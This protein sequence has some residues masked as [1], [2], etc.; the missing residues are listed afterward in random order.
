MK[1]YI[2]ALFLLTTVHYQL[3]AQD[4]PSEIQ[5][6]N[7]NRLISGAGEVTGLYDPTVVNK[8]ELILEESN[9]FTLL[10]GSGG[11]G[12]GGGGPNSNPG[13]ELMGTLIFNDTVVLDSV[14]I[15]IKGET[16]DFANNS[17]KKSFSVSI[18]SIVNQDLLGYDN[19]NLNCGFQDPSGM[20]EVLYCNAT[21]SFAP[22]LK[23][24]IVDLYINGES[25]GP[26]ANVQQIEGTYIKEWFGSNDGT[27]W[28]CVSPEGVG[29]PGG[30]GG[31]GGPGGGG[32][33]FGLGSSTL[34]WLGTESAEY[35]E[36][37][38]LKNTNKDDPWQDLIDACDE[39][40]NT[41]SI[42]LYNLAKKVDIDRAL[43]FLAQ[44]I[45]FADDDS[46][47]NKG[48][49]DYYAYFDTDTDR[50]IPLEVDGNSVMYTENVNWSIYYNENDS[51]YVLQNRL[52]QNQELKQRYLSHVRVILE[53]NFNSEILEPA[54]DNYAALL[55]ARVQADPKAIYSYNEYLN[56]LDEL[57]EFVENR[58]ALFMNN[59]DV[60]QTELVINEPTLSSGNGIE[61][62]PAGGEE[63]EI[64]VTINDTESQ[65][66]NRVVL[67]YGQ[68]IQGAFERVTMA[69]QGN[70][71]YTASIASYP[72]GAYVRYY[73]EAVADNSQQTSSYLP[74]GAEHD[75]YIYQV[76]Q[77]SV[78]GGQVVINEL[79]AVND[80]VN[81]DEE[82][83]FDDWIE[84]YNVGDEAVNLSGYY[85]TDSENDLLKY[86]FPENTILEGDDYLLVWAD[87]NTEQ[88][89][90]HA[91]FKLS[92]GG[93][94]VILSN[95][96]GGQVDRVDFD[97]QT[98]DQSYSRIPNGT[99]DFVIKNATPGFNNEETVSG[100]DDLN[101]AEY[102][103]TPN[104]ATDAITLKVNQKG[105]YRV[106]I[107]TLLGQ[108]VLKQDCQ[109]SEVI[110]ISQLT[111]GSYLLSVNQSSQM[112]IIQ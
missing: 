6:I 2:V 85:L 11:G 55:D 48:G 106:S 90:Y 78:A 73:I 100:L 31:P 20:R 59:N 82:G 26:Y 12:P 75:I 72:A 57:K 47:V 92:S 98:I 43:W 104:P 27:R 94:S 56:D 15:G 74:K 69:D 62:A 32:T 24:N 89:A 80:A 110:D 41:P 44:E 46:Y 61:E 86:Q 45:V 33:Q 23:A 66:I 88:S 67:Y 93:E 76:A 54:I 60:D 29:G 28:R 38:S 18:D 1:Y 71:T 34:N 83:E 95:Q 50:L 97:E 42:E 10:D 52:F 105:D 53:E 102:S 77:A 9:W 111:S 36:A 81:A 16:S 51:R 14:I 68:G 37:Y 58:H 99:G 25:W 5:V 70:N 30:G 65:G 17:E 91:D 49:S 79:L 64:S 22:A 19:I 7:D 21:R 35:Q 13:V 8:I 39:L 84:L 4:L 109:Q 101:F 87:G 63:A 96:D 108:V 107:S 112:L 103:I 40:N 3:I